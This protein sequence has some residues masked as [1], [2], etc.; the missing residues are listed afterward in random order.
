STQTLN[1]SHNPN[2]NNHS[3]T[4]NNS[5]AILN[6]TFNNN[7]S[8]TNPSTNSPYHNIAL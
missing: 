1:I 3:N 4:T 5:E 7:H 8:N 2:N 6:I